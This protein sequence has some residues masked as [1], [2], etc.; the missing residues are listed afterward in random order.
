MTSDITNLKKKKQML[1]I[2]EKQEFLKTIID[3][4]KKYPMEL[5]IERR[6]KEYSFD[7]KQVNDTDFIINMTRTSSFKNGKPFTQQILKYIQNEHYT[8]VF[9]KLEPIDIL[10]HRLEI[11]LQ[12]IQFDHYHQS[13][14]LDIYFYYEVEES[15]PLVL[16]IDQKNLIERVYKPKTEQNYYFMELKDKSLSDVLTILESMLIQ[17]KIENYARFEASEVYNRTK[18]QLKKKYNI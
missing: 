3:L 10:D 7:I 16:T 6:P 13:N 9:L 5:S 15:K 11:N 18:K 12:E 14:I 8:S 4:I 17:F 2:N 1:T